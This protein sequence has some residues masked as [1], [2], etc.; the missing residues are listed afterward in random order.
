MRIRMSA[1]SFLLWI[2]NG[3]DELST[4]EPETWQSRCLYALAGEIQVNLMEISAA[5]AKKVT[6]LPIYFWRH[7][8]GYYVITFTK[9]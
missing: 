3:L 1:Y 7:V 5:S 4:P 2:S 9:I 8:A 6:P